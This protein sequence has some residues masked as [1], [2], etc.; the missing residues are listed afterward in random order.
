MPE[1]LP[2]ETLREVVSLFVRLV[3]AAGAL[4]IFAGAAVAFVRFLLVAVRREEQGFVSVRLFLGRFLVLGLEF[5]LAGDVL[6]T[7]V[8]PSFG[9]IGQLAAI[10]TIR[11]A[12]NFFLGKEIEREGRAVDAARPPAPGSAG[13]PGR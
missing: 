7:A 9:Q 13:G 12:L 1:L 4:V 8:A 6:R 10:A 3:E 11:T 5:Q 2:E